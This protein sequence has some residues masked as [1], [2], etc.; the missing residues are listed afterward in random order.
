M[1]RVFGWCL[2]QDDQGCMS[3]SRASPDRFAGLASA[4]DSQ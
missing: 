2:G 4:N 1:H 3:S